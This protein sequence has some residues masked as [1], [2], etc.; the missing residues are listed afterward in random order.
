MAAT[1]FESMRRHSPRSRDFWRTPE[2]LTAP[3]RFFIGALGALCCIALGISGYLAITALRSEDVAG[4]GGGAYLDCGYALHSRW[5][6]VLS[7]PVSVPAFALYAVLLAALI[8][9]RV[10]VARARVGLAWGTITVGA[11]AAGIAAMWFIGLQVFSVGHLCPY[12][13]AAH[14]CGLALFLVILWKPPMGA[15]TTAKLSGVSVLGVTALAAAQ[16]FSAPPP[17]FRIERHAAPAVNIAPTAAATDPAVV[18]HNHEKSRVAEIFEPPT[19]LPD[20][21]T[22]R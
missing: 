16:V 17:T 2:S 3:P 1:T 20:D 7:L 10:P 8:G 13:M 12:C 4:C 5:S 6:K 18:S 15:R 19:G 14:F 11:I 9:C 22:Q 21:Q